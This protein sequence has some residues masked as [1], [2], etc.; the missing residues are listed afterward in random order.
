[1]L[2]AKDTSMFWET[3][4]IW[5]GVDFKTWKKLS[6]GGE[7]QHNKE[8][9][10]LNTTWDV[11]MMKEKESHKTKK[12]LSNGTI[13]AAQFKDMLT[14]NTTWDVVMMKEKESHKTKKKLSNGTMIAAQQGHADAQYNLG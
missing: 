14:L 7:M 9:L 13:C 5:E 11:V 10:K 3:I 6:S 12:K 4:I 1:M 2:T 8:I